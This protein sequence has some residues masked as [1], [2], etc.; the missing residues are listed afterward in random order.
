MKRIISLLILLF[1][2]FA[3]GEVRSQSGWEYQPYP[4]IGDVRDLKFFDANTGLVSIYDSHNYIYYLIRTTNSGY[5]WVLIGNLVMFNIEIIDTSAVYCWGRNISAYDI[6]FRSTDRGLNWDSTINFGSS[7][8]GDISFINRDTGWVCGYNNFN[9]II[10]RTTDG[11]QSFQQQF[12]EYNGGGFDQIYIYK[13]PVNGYYHGWCTRNNI[14][15]KTTNSGQNWF[16]TNT[17]FPISVNVNQFEF[18]NKDTGWV[19]SR[20]P[21]LLKTTDGG[22]NW[23]LQPL[24]TGNNIVVRYIFLFDVINKDTIFGDMGIRYFGGLGEHGIIWVTTNGGTNWGFQQ[25]DTVEIKIPFYR[26]IDFVNGLTGWSSKIHTTNGGGPIIYTGID[27]EKK[28]VPK[29]FVLNQNYPNPF[30]GV[31]VITFELYENSTVN[32]AVFDITGREILKI[33]NSKELSAGNYKTILDFSK[34]NL[35]TGIYFCRLEVTDKKNNPVFYESI[36]MIYSK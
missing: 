14:L 36:K 6:I 10:W 24:P 25:P 33:Y 12:I 19:S 8:I 1:I 27:D 20:T 31:T 5:N 17:S 3:I 29:S 18:I 9:G 16:Y 28:T 30:N 21:G 4:V 22:F 13:K 7:G 26:G 15:L 32:M 34:I 2:L 11:C 35:T 23:V